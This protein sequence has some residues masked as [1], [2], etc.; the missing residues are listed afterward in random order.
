MTTKK[1]IEKASRETR[2]DLSSR[3]A[4]VLPPSE[5]TPS[6][7][8]DRGVSPAITEEATELDLKTRNRRVAD[9][10]RFLGEFLESGG[11][12]PRKTRPES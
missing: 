3:Q 11:Q 4:P 6:S 2:T 8:R 1:P 9:F 7:S 10:F 12:V 5:S